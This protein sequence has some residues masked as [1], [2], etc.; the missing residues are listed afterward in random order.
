MLSRNSLESYRKLFHPD[1]SIFYHRR[2]I[3]RVTWHPSMSMDSRKYRTISSNSQFIQNSIGPSFRLTDRKSGCPKTNNLLTS[4]IF[5]PFDT[6]FHILPEFFR[7]LLP[8]GLMIHR[9]RSY[10]KT[11]S[12]SLYYCR[13]A[14]CNPSYHKKGSFRIGRIKNINNPAYIPLNSFFKI[15]PL[16][17]ATR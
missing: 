7:R 15:Y 3:R 13:V 4:Y 6:L 14:L 17:F 9:M 12:Y 16:C 10:L 5:K 2:T 8:Y 1:R 11:L